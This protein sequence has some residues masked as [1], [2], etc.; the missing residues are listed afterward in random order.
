MPDKSGNYNIMMLPIVDVQPGDY[1]LSLNEQTQKIEPHRINALLDM[2]I[3]PVYRLTTQSG[4]SI[5]TTINHPYLVRQSLIN[6]ATTEGDVVAQFIGQ[7]PQWLKVK[8]LKVGDEIGVPRELNGHA[9]LSYSD[10][11]QRKAESRQTQEIIKLQLWQT[12]IFSFPRKDNYTTQKRNNPK[13]YKSNPQN[14]RQLFKKVTNTNALNNLSLRGSDSDRSNLKNGIASPSARNDINCVRISKTYSQNSLA[15]ISYNL[16]NKFSGRFINSYHNFQWQLYHACKNLS[17][18]AYAEVVPLPLAQSSSP[19]THSIDKP[20]AMSHEPLAEGEYSDIF[21]DRI[22]SIEYCGYEH[23][24]DIEVEGTH[25]FIG[26]N[27]FAHNTAIGSQ[28]EPPTASQPKRQ[29]SPA[30]FSRSSRNNKR[31]DSI[32]LTNK[33]YIGER[34]YDTDD[35]NTMEGIKEDV[36]VL[37]TIPL[38]ESVF[39]IYG[40]S[41][42]EKLAKYLKEK[43]DL[44]QA[45]S[46]SKSLHEGALGREISIVLADK[47]DYLAGDHRQNNLIILNASDIEAMLEDN[48]VDEEAKS[49]YVSEFLTS[50]LSEELAHER[51]AEGDTDTEERLAKAC[52]LNSAQFFMSQGKNIIDYIEFL[53]KYTGGVEGQKDYSAYLISETLA[54]IISNAKEGDF[55]EI[56]RSYDYLVIRIKGSGYVL[57]VPLRDNLR[58]QQEYQFAKESLRNRVS[59]LQVLDTIKV[60]KAKIRLKEERLPDS[61]CIESSRDEITF[62]NFILSL[63]FK[64]MCDVLNVA[65]AERDNETMET[66]R[67]SLFSLFIEAAEKGLSV[68]I[69]PDNFGVNEVGKVYIFDYGD[70]KKYEDVKKAEWPL[71]VDNTAKALIEKLSIR[72]EAKYIL[73]DEKALKALEDRLAAIHID[74]A[75]LSLIGKWAIVGEITTVDLEDVRVKVSF[76][77]RNIESDKAEIEQV[78]LF[79]RKASPKYFEGILDTLPKEANP[80]ISKLLEWHKNLPGEIWQLILEDNVYNIQ[81]MGAKNLIAVSENISENPM[82]LLHE[83]MHIAEQSDVLKIDINEEGNKFTYIFTDPETAEETLY[84]I[85]DRELITWFKGRIEKY[86]GVNF[87]DIQSHYAIRVFQ[88]YLLM[89]LDAALT[90]AVRLQAIR[91]TIPMQDAMRPNRGIIVD[92]SPRRPD[93]IITID[94]RNLMYENLMRNGK[95]L[96]VE[97]DEAGVVKSLSY[98]KKKKGGRTDYFVLDE[99]FKDFPEFKQEAGFEDGVKITVEIA[100]KKIYESEADFKN[101]GVRHILFVIDPGTGKSV[102][103][104]Q[105]FSFNETKFNAMNFGKIPVM[106]F[107]SLIYAQSNL[108]FYEHN[109]DIGS[110]LYLDSYYYLLETL[111]HEIGAIH[112]M[113]NT[114]LGAQEAHNKL[115]EWERRMTQE[116]V[117]EKELEDDERY[118]GPEAKSYVDIFNEE[119]HINAVS[120][121]SDYKWEPAVS[122]NNGLGSIYIKRKKDE[123]I[124]KCGLRAGYDPAKDM[125][126]LLIGTRKIL[127]GGEELEG[128]VYQNDGKGYVL[129]RKYMPLAHTISSVAQVFNFI[130]SQTFVDSLYLKDS[131]RF[132]NILNLEITY[133]KNDTI[134]QTIDIIFSMIYKDKHGGVIFPQMAVFIFSS[135]ETIIMDPDYTRKEIYGDD[136]D[137]FIET[138]KLIWYLAMLKEDEKIPQSLPDNETF[139]HNLT[140][141]GYMEFFGKKDFLSGGGGYHR[142]IQEGL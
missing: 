98:Y 3:K 113:Y 63:D 60:Q 34:E 2:G 86:P 137:S 92:K 130:I 47:Y 6:Q 33:F 81:G 75:N 40:L 64:N 72:D 58:R 9:F 66:I 49:A 1:V 17:S 29:A 31:N 95:F 80:I 91:N 112:Y 62:T 79:A 129:I 7:R 14:Y 50:L 37:E 120:W 139:L 88:R 97:V 16:C 45:I 122:V 110:D 74:E 61:P 53:D 69:K 73:G 84:E 20:R 135:G 78:A 10:N 85:K 28:S 105:Y 114:D 82:A 89:K 100:L 51:G 117:R 142:L 57:K 26:N 108:E 68:K 116:G 134:G 71:T 35:N 127:V 131:D 70:V 4:R 15:K 96:K 99:F 118:D 18:N 5:K 56:S 46:R 43:P 44:L 136:S 128:A 55:E 52:A 126:Y 32:L 23:V 141:P 94:D 39:T 59:G 133:H 54:K 22:V 123:T 77:A 119:R 109:K 115:S 103:G 124:V 12:L 140:L 48:S 93:E 41:G 107:G 13:Y 83:I 67:D 21:W 24:Y 38:D 25:N 121:P 76:N 101:A 42:R 138:A 132:N 90:K 19:V 111:G 102:T 27:I 36:N 30:H 87:E 106:P 11:Y 125:A 65:A 8:D 104:G